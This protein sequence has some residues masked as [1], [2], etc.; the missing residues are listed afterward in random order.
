[1]EEEGEEEALDEKVG[2]FRVDDSDLG[3]EPAIEETPRKLN[4]TTDAKARA[5]E[6]GLTLRWR[7]LGD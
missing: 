4:R 2:A 1:V 5:R 6:R 7:G 3:I